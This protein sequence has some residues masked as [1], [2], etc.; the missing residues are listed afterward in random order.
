M[1]GLQRCSTSFLD[2][3]HAY[4]AAVYP[5]ASHSRQRGGTTKYQIRQDF[6]KHFCDSAPGHGKDAG[7]SNVF[8]LLQVSYDS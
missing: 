8:C 5:S 2:V 1:L 3:M 7:Y 6:L 4:R